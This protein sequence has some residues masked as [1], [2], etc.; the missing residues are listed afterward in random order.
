MQLYSLI[1]N[2]EKLLKLINDCLKPIWEVFT[3]TALVNEML[4]K[5]ML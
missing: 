4:D 1:D 3:P 5:S 2:P